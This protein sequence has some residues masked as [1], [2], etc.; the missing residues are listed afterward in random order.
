MFGWQLLFLWHKEILIILKDPIN[1]IILIMPVIVQTI[2][3]GYG[4]TFDLNHAPIAVLDQSKS[5]VSMELVRKINASGLFV[6]KAILH[7][8]MQINS[9]I[10]NNQALL[11]LHIG[12]DFA[13]NL[14]KIGSASVQIIL[15]GRNSTTAAM[16][17]GHLHT[18]IA[19]FNAE[20]LQVR[21]PLK[22]TP[23]IWFNPNLEMRNVTATGLIVTLSMIQVLILSALSVAREREQATFDQLLVTPLTPFLILL[24]KA[25][26]PILIGI[27]QSSLILL[28][29]LFLFK[30]PFMGNLLVLFLGITI[31]TASCVGLGLC[32]SA[33]ARNMQ[34]AMVFT[35]VLVMPLVL[36]SGLLTPISNMPEFLQV[37]TFANPLRFGLD[38]VRS[39]YLEG[40]SLLDI[41]PNFIPM[42]ILA[43]ITMPLAAWLF[44][45]RMS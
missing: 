19:E 41:A 45:N 2:I 42:L 9:V 24:G 27:G 32:I 31:F 44:R 16:A 25:L 3:F 15:D 22:I 34:Q 1:R 20:V 38:M 10:D 26:P 11:V 6:T 43:L 18:L 30:I 40:A 4:A 35:F 33:L 37:I 7:S 29:A 36:L 39:I 21:S 14:T 17:A 5:Q 12:S 8:P 28:I 13:Q 23:R